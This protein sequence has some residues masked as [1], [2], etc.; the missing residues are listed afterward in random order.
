M[1]IKKIGYYKRFAELKEQILELCHTVM[2]QNH[3]SLQYDA[4]T[5]NTSWLNAYGEDKAKR[6]IHFNKLQPQL[7]GTE[8][9]KLFQTLN[10]PMVRTRIFAINPQTVGYT[11]HRDYTARI[12]IPIVTEAGANFYSYEPTEKEGNFMPADGSI[13]Y[14]DTRVMHTFKNLSN[15]VRIHLV[16]C[17]YGE[18][19]WK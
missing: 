9:D 14:V 8:I 11:P 6:E 7:V 1:I 17:Y 2:T 15:V 19:K 4:E 10:I 3:I 18:D 5:G 12:H 13:Y 16:G